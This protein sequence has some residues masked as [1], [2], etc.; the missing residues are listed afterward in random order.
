MEEPKRPTRIILGVNPETYNAKVSEIEAKISTLTQTTPMTINVGIG[1]DYETINE[2]LSV[3]STKSPK[4]VQKGL[5][6]EL[7]LMSGFVM[8]E[9]VIVNGLNLGWISITSVDDIVTIDRGSLSETVTFPTYDGGQTLPITTNGAFV[10]VNNAVLPQIKALFQMNETGT[11]SNRDGVVVCNNSSVFI[12]EGCGVTHAGGKGLYVL[13]ASKAAAMGSVF[14]HAGGGG[15][16]VFR[17]SRVAFRGGNASYAGG[18]G[19]Y[20]DSSSDCEALKADFSNATGIGVYVDSSS[21]INCNHANISNCG[22]DGIR[23]LRGGWVDAAHATIN[24]TVGTG[25]RCI[26]G[27]FVNVSDAEIKNAGI[28]GIRCEGAATVNASNAVVT[29]AGSRGIYAL[30]GGRVNAYKAN[31]RKVIDVDS[32]DDIRIATGGIV[33]AE[34]ATGGTNVTENTI[35][36]HGIIWR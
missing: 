25:V 22:T 32:T 26:Q 14:S 15:V 27:A 35:T 3:L 24:D 23:A 16:G 18:H 4:Y 1:G 9:Q 11:A 29:G 10:G 28:D 30:L 36:V 34:Q 20:L 31:C 21:R 19:I 5:N 17:G 2:A 6:V 12:K 33:A 7:K 8:R 13:Q